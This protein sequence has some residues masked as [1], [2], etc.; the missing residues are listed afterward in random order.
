N[1]MVLNPFLSGYHVWSGKSSAGAIDGQGGA[2]WNAGTLTVIDCTLSN[3]Y[4]GANAGP[5]QPQAFAGGAISNAG[6]LTVR[7]S[8]LH[9]NGAGYESVGGTLY[10]DDSVPGEGGAIYNAYKASATVTASTVD[11][12]HA[13]TGGGGIWNEG[14]MTLSQTI[15]SANW[16]GSDGGGIFN[17]KPGHLTIQS[18][19]VQNNTAPLGAD[20]YNLGVDKI[21]QDSI[22][23]V[24]GR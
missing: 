21:S 19:V 18:S 11:D 17:T 3:N 9:H 12:N 15:V 10:L 20:L 14:T 22:V 13:H 8:T 4:A 1:G 16:A 23:G 7:T 24:I 5:D 2:I 6:K